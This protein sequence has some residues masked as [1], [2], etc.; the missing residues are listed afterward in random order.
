MRR[1]KCGFTLIELLVVIAIIAILAAI[2]LPALARAREAARRASCQNN[3]KQWGIIFKMFAGENKDKWVLRTV[4]WDQNYTTNLGTRVWHGI[5]TTWIYPEYMTD[6][7]IY[8]CP[9]DIDPG[10]LVNVQRAITTGFTGE[11]QF[12]LLRKLGTG[13]AG[14]PFPIASQT[15]LTTDLDGNGTVNDLDCTVDR[16]GCYLYG[17][18]WSY[19]YWGVAIPGKYVSNTTDSKAVF[20]FLHNGSATRLGW[21][22]NAMKDS[23]P[24]DVTL[25][26]GEKPNILRLREGVERFFITDINNPAGSSQAQST[27]PVMWD[28]IRTSG[29]SLGD[30]SISEGG[31]DFCHIP[32]GANILF[33]DGHVE[34]SKY[35]SPAGS[36]NWV[37]STPLLTDASQ[38]SP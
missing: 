3:L 26:T 17:A 34:F 10:P 30:S 19:S 4:R 14:Q 24:L 21:L 8:K 33:M 35:P 9:S 1:R 2:L 11:P 36:A 29:G 18:D 31:K 6:W 28:T 27:L 5:D 37:T 13:W 23:F 25:T 38:Y 15:P 7:G 32:G 16:S 12:G 22:C 20:D